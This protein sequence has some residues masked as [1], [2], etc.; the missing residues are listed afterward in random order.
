MQNEMRRNVDRSGHALLAQGPHGQ[1]RTRARARERAMSHMWVTD[2]AMIVFRFV[3]F[4][5]SPTTPRNVGRN[6][7]HMPLRKRLFSQ[8]SRRTK[9]GALRELHQRRDAPF[10][11]LDAGT[12]RFSLFFYVIEMRRFFFSAVGMRCFSFSR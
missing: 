10:N 6:H 5:A 1:H 2:P 3:V 9:N 4:L 8:W 7:I 11:L 12:R